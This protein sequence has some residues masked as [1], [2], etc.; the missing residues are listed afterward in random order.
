LMHRTEEKSLAA[1][2]KIMIQCCMQGLI[3]CFK[4]KNDKHQD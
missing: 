3:A 1:D 4:Q 2:K